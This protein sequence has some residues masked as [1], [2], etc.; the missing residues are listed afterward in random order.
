MIPPLHADDNLKQ[1][2]RR[3]SRVSEHLHTPLLYRKSTSSMR[4]WWVFNANC[5]RMLD[6]LRVG[7]LKVMRMRD[8]LNPR[9]GSEKPHPPPPLSTSSRRASNNTPIPAFQPRND[10]AHIRRLRCVTPRSTQEVNHQEPETMES[11]DRRW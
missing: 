1:R 3:V 7:V 10:L 2:L 5:H 4:F 11:L 6:F 8:C 9:N